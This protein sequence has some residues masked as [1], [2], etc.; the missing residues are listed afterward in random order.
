ME[1]FWWL[2]ATGSS[3]CGNAEDLSK[4]SSATEVE[5]GEG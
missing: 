4:I 2:K 1:A 3:Y 5:M